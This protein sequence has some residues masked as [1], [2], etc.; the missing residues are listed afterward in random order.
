MHLAEIFA[1]DTL[2]T[3]RLVLR[4]FTHEDAPEVHRAWQD[5]RF[6]ASAPVGYPYAGADLETALA[7]CTTGIEQRRLEG[8]G[9][10][11]AVVPHTGTPLVGHVSLFGT[12]WQARTCEIHYWTA[13]WARGHGYAAEAAAAVAR[14]ALTTQ[15]QARITLQVD[16]ANPAS[17]R[18]AERAGF[19]FEGILRSV[20]ESRAGGR[21]DMAVYSLITEDLTPAHV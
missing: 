1:R 20:A 6:I 21:A 8:K 3:D 5:E 16:T 10:G 14:W 4:P 19:H 13:P 12:D 18:V 2:T 9:V 15:R 7:W 11:F 17:R